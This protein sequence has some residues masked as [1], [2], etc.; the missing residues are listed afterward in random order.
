MLEIGVLCGGGFFFISV[1]LMIVVE[2]GL[3]KLDI[4]VELFV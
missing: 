2:I 1:V 4:V 3:I